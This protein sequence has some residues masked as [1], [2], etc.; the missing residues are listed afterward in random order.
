ME[1][2]FRDR[3]KVAFAEYRLW[4]PARVADWPNGSPRVKVD[5]DGEMKKFH[6]QYRGTTCWHCNSRKGEELH[7]A[8]SGSRGRSHERTLFFWLCKDCHANHVGTDNL[9]R[10]LYAKWK[11]DRDGLDWVRLAIRLGRHLPD[12]DVP[13]D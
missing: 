12:L 13:G 3:N 5:K 6:Q 11:Y 4:L 10:L 8:A 9:G 2:D 1:K 7:H